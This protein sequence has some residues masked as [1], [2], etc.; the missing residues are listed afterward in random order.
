MSQRGA[1]LR[2]PSFC[3]WAKLSTFITTPSVMYGS[4]GLIFSNAWMK[5]I[6][7]S[8]LAARPTSFG[9]GSPQALS[10]CVHS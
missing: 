6:A 1:L 3:R 5:A 9:T 4:L 7:S 2:A 8:M 10:V